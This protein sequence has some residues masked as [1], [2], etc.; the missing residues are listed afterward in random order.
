MATQTIRQQETTAIPGISRKNIERAGEHISAVG[1][2]L[3]LFIFAPL[4]THPEVKLSE[5][6]TPMEKAVTDAFRWGVPL[7]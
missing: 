5:S 3:S 6:M 1:K 4:G 7:F 2:V